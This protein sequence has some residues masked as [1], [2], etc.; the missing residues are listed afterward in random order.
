MKTTRLLAILVLFGWLPLQAQ[1][2]D[3][4][5]IVLPDRAQSSDFG[6]KL[7]QLAWKNHPTNEILRRELMIAEYQVGRSAAD[8]LDLITIQG[9]INEFN[10]KAQD[11]TVPVFLPRYNFGISIP[12]GVFVG[13][14]NE[15][16]QNKQRLAIAQE[17]I[18][19]QKL[20]VRRVVLKS[21]NEYQ[22]Q[23]KIFKIQSQQFSD[24]ESNFKLIEQRF[25][26]GELTFE[27]YTASQADLNRAS[28][29]LLQTDRDLRNAKLDLE[30]LVGVKL[31]DVM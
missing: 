25:K 11:A 5:K 9:N 24:I 23:E 1:I 29:Q 19:A 14:P 18:N 31:E 26:N 20:E 2:I 16:K 22:L 3:Y 7:V 21:Y 30:Q 17:E 8:W 4:N 28:I 15:T 6:E 12:L 27:A 10:I 13:N